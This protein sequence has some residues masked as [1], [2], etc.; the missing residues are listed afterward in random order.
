M[1]ETNGVHVTFSQ[2][3][4]MCSDN[5]PVLGLSGENGCAGFV[6]WSEYDDVD[7]CN[8]KAQY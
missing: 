6:T 8:R 5:L 2:N 3:Q 1:C 7:N 4:W